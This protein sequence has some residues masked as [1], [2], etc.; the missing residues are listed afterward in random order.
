M[1]SFNLKRA[2][3]FKIRPSV[4]MTTDTSFNLKVIRKPITYDDARKK[5]SI[6]Y[7][8]ERHGI[9]QNTAKINPSIIVLHYTAG[10]TIKS[11]YDYFNQPNIENERKYNGKYSN[12]NVSSHYLIDRDGTVYQLV[13][14]T[15]FARHTIGLN[16][17]AIG[18]ENIGGPKQP[19]TKEQVI[20]NAKLVRMLARKFPIEYVIGH[21]EYGIFRKSKLWK[22][23]DPSYFTQKQD[24][25][26]DFMEQV[27]KLITDL[28]I[29]KQP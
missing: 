14:D 18:V 17:C 8:E 16:Y 27:R 5:S 19:L 29:K 21:S 4:E 10:G 13:D 6:K 12:L 2:D 3:F 26:N 15:L 9:L 23:K 25:G 7:L 22:E 24:P 28:K 1:P 20:S 11:T